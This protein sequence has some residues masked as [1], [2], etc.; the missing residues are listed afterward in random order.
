MLNSQIINTILTL[1]HIHPALIIPNWKLDVTP[2]ECPNH[3]L[4]DGSP[5]FPR[6]LLQADHCPAKDLLIDDWSSSSSCPPSSSS[7]YVTGSSSF[8]SSSFW[9]LS[10]LACCLSSPQDKRVISE[11]QY[12]ANRKTTESESPTI[13]MWNTEFVPLMPVAIAAAVVFLVKAGM[14]VYI[15]E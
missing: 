9:L 11:V 3:T 5:L 8:P 10:F 1:P 2:A 12:D 6:P 13:T 7:S 4:H 15:A 14:V